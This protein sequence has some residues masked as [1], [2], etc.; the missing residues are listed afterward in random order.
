MP[1]GAVGGATWSNQP[2]FS[3]YISNSAVFDQTSGF[4]TSASSTSDVNHSPLRDEAAGCSSKPSGGTT[5]ETLG[6]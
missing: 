5:Q 1:F 2:S 4:E 3:S 6:S